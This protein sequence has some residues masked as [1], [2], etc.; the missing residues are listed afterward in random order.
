MS[1]M[2][3]FSPSALSRSA[4][5]NPIPLAPPVTRATLAVPAD[6][7]VAEAVVAAVAVLSMRNATRCLRRLPDGGRSRPGGRHVTHQPLTPS[8]LL[9]TAARRLAPL[10]A[11]P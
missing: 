10:A 3:T 8:P 1:A 2:A 11:L 6:S 5:A 9:P 7:S 4:H